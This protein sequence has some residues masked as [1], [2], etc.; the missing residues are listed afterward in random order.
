[1]ESTELRNKLEDLINK[2][3]L[4]TDK[5]SLART[6]DLRGMVA[7]RQRADGL[8]DFRIVILPNT[9]GIPHLHDIAVEITGYEPH[10]IS[11]MNHGHL[12]FTGLPQ[13]TYTLKI[14][15]NNR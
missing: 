14:A 11:V 9:S 13:G 4:D 15:E 7:P 1:M 10:T 3:R 12:Y 5:W 8:T 6:D 2:L